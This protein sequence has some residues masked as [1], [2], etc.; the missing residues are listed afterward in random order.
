LTGTG[1]ILLGLLLGTMM[2]SD[3]GGPINKVAYGFAVAGLSTGSVDNPT[4]WMIMA[5]VMAAD[6]LRVI[7]AAIVGSA[8]T[9]A[10]SMAAG[11]T[12]QAPHGG[13]F[14]SFAI[15]NLL[16]FTVAIIVGAIL[17]ALTVVALKRWVRRRPVEETRSAAPAVAA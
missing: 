11:V 12:S 5:A 6:P 16:M 4:P 14:V 1:V 10:M 7:P 17:T 9:G 3:L 8:A 15:G 2:A 13:F